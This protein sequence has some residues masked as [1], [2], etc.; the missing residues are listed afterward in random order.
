MKRKILAFSATLA[1]LMTGC[2]QGTVTEDKKDEFKIGIVQ[3]MEIGALDAAREGFIEE[4]NSSDLNIV[5]DEK[6]AQGEITNTK[7]IADK[8]ANDKVDL[9]YAIATPSAQ[10]ASAST[11]DIPVVFSAVTDPVQAKLVNSLESSGNNVTGVSDMVDIKNQLELFRQI[12]KDINTIGVIY[13]ADESNSLQQ[14]KLVEEFSKELG[15]NVESVSIQNLSDVPQAIESI[16]NKIDCLYLLSDSK[17]SSASP[18]V[19]EA[20]IRE[21]IPVVAAVESDVNLGGLISLGIDYKELGKISAKQAIEILKGKKPTEIEVFMPNQFKK[22]VNKKTMDSLGL[23][24][25]LEVF[26]DAVFVE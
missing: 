5:I 19:N 15:F 13:S 20:M 25:N 18:L 23:D 8:F 17:I 3:F 21:N 16:I 6:N 12:N 11:S 22:F 4:I 14:L 9:I 10:S 26:K 24:Q 1:L 7:T 2:N